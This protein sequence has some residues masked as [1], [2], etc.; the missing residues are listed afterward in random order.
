MGGSRDILIVAPDP[1]LPHPEAV[2]RRPGQL[3][4]ED[5]LKLQSQGLPPD[6]LNELDIV[7]TRCKLDKECKIVGV[8]MGQ[9]LSKEE[10]T[11]SI[12][13]LLSTTTNDG[14]RWIPRFQHPP[15]NYMVV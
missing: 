3:T 7:G 2:A 10:I 13:Y 9:S 11:K 6:C 12:T 4:E 15:L 5:K 8:K 14:G 1:S